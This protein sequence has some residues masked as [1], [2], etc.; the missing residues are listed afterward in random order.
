[1]PKNIYIRNGVYWGR[2]EVAGREYRKSLHVRVEPA[3][4]AEA[5]AVQSLDRVRLEIEDQIRHAI[6][7]PKL[8]QEVV[9]AWH[10]HAHAAIS[11]NAL[12]RY[13]VSLNQCR[14]WLDGKAIHQVDVACLR[15][16]IKARRSAGVS[17]ATI[18]RDLTAISAV[19]STAQDEGWIQDNPSP[20]CPRSCS[21]D[22]MVR[23]W[24][25]C[26]HSSERR[27]GGWCR[28]RHKSRHSAG[29]PSYASDSTIC[30][31]FSRFA[32]CKK[33]AQSMHFRGFW[34]TPA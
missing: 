33:A 26:P 4:R 32:T 9:I 7:P 29:T 18:R 15:E 6:T 25:G 31:I 19:L 1:M 12:K 13:L 22:L 11:E 16:L 2:F 24:I 14:A 10:E 30:A 8:W 20:T 17:N 5:K 23:R 3:K 28:G 21:T 27:H 34:G